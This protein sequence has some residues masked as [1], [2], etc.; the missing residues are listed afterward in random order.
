MTST[1]PAGPGDLAALVALERDC[2]GAGAWSADLL[3]G[4]LA[5]LPDTGSVLV[6]PADADVQAYAVLMTV[7]DVADLAR[8]A[9]SP[10]ARRR[11]L[12]RTL[13][14][15]ARAQ[16]V[17]R[18]CERMLLEVRADNLGALALYAAAGFQ[19]I[20]VRRGYYGRGVDA[21]VMLLRL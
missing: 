7:A 10:G 5:R 20:H 18:G 16:A 6:A 2:F 19:P 12:G 13:L 3:A 8:I 4:E 17:T 1:R 15:D 11:G 21:A 14:A 9:V